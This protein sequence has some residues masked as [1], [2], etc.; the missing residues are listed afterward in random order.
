MKRVRTSSFAVVSMRKALRPAKVPK[1]CGRCERGE[2]RSQTTSVLPS[3]TLSA[4][5]H[6]SWRI[7]VF[8]VC[9]SVTAITREL[10][11]NGIA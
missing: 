4:T 11:K 6:S 10:A 8:S 7:A 9:E 5:S 2:S 1:G 3:G